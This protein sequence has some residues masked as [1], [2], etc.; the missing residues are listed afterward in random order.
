MGSK[1]AQGRPI[2]LRLP[3]TQTPDLPPPTELERLGDAYAILSL[4]ARRQV[5]ELFRPAL[6]ALGVQR[7]GQL[8]DTRPGKVRIAG[9]VVTRQHP[10]TARGTVFL[11]LEDE[12]A[13]VNVTL[14]PDTWARFRGVV[15]RHAL[16]YIEGQLERESDVVNVIAN[17]VKSLVEVARPAGGPSRPRGRSP[18]GPRRHAAGRLA[19]LLQ[20]RQV[21][22][23]V[24]VAAAFVVVVVAAVRACFLAARS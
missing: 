1:K 14:W 20:R 7:A 8:V 18:H 22:G 11:A 4:D 24:S 5:I 2:D 17:D 3:P 12:T 10:M 15:R 16:L 6:D 21:V 9:L 13:M 19:R 23:L